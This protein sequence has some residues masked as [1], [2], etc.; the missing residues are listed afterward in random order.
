MRIA[1]SAAYSLILLLSL[2]QAIC[3]TGM[4]LISEIALAASVNA[5][6]FKA[7][8]Y[9]KADC[10][11]LGTCLATTLWGKEVARVARRT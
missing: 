2:Q 1:N 10:G 9:E 8:G 4:G 11:Y 5:K 7:P 3:P 6:L